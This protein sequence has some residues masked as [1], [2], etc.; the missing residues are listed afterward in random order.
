MAA[1]CVIKVRNA[2]LRR[3]VQLFA[4]RTSMSVKLRTWPA[5]SRHEYRLFFS[6]LPE[7]TTALVVIDL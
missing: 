4:Q 7:L 3:C 1:D 5:I 2:Q 6:L